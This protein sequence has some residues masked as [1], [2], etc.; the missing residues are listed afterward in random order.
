MVTVSL[1]VLFDAV[2]SDTP[3]GT[4]MVAVFVSVVPD[5]DVPVIVNVTVPPT[6]T[7]IVASMSPLPLPLDG[8]LAPP[9]AAQ[10]HD[11]PLSPLGMLSVIRALVTPEGP[12]LEMTTLETTEDAVADVWL[13]LMARSA[14][15]GLV[16]VV[17]GG[18]VVVVVV[19]V[20]AGA[21]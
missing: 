15:G 21:A 7:L 17:A 19:V 14:V 8:Q 16:V 18:S 3:F 13:T 2:G 5:D 20:G 4:A 1:A 12:L 9:V 11:A 6:V 10:V